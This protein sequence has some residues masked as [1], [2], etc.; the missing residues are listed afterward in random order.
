MLHAYVLLPY[1]SDAREPAGH[2][3]TREGGLRHMRRYM[4]VYLSGLLFIWFP[5][6]MYARL[7]PTFFLSVRS[8]PDSSLPH[9]LHIHIHVHVHAHPIHAAMSLTTSQLYAML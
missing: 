1:P 2:F 5:A 6:G 8:T 9:L 7:R 4:Y 3:N